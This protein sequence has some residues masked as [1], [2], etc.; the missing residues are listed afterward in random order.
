MVRLLGFLKP[1]PEGVKPASLEFGIRPIGIP[2]AFRRM[3]ARPLAARA[4]QR[5][6]QRLLACG[7][8]GCGVPSGVD[9]GPRLLQLLV[10]AA[11]RCWTAALRLLSGR[12]IDKEMEQKTR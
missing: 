6:Q 9:P 5:W 8:T 3:A 4:T 2:C 10:A 7:Q 11:L 12:C 1:D